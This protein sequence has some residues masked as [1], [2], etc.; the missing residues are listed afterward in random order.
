MF[1]SG[2]EGFEGGVTAKKYV[3]IAKASK[4]TATRNLQ[5]NQLLS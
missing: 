5:S 1:E 4:A 3:A 2:V